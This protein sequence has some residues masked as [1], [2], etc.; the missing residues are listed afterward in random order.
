VVRS[1]P[2][3]R[4]GKLRR[5][6]RASHRRLF[7]VR[8]RFARVSA[9]IERPAKL[10][11]ITSQIAL[12]V[13]VGAVLGMSV[14]VFNHYSPWSLLTVVRH[15]A[16]VPNCTAA[17]TVGLAPAEKGHPGYYPSHDADGDGIACEPFPPVR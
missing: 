8:Q 16:A 13:W 14:A 9:R 5:R 4:N 12:A 3:T 10:R 15:V 7:E 17:R 2:P 1:L 6:D 11:R